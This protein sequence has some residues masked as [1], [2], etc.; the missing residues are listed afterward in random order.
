MKSLSR[1]NCGRDKGGSNKTGQ[2]HFITKPLSMEI[3]GKQIC[4]LPYMID[5]NLADYPGIEQLQDDFY[6]EQV[7]TNNKNQILSAKL[8]LLL[9]YFVSPLMK[10]GMGGFVTQKSLTVIHHYYFDGVAFPG[11]KSKFSFRDVA[12]SSSRLDHQ[13]LQFISGHLHQP[14]YHKNYLCTGS[15]RAQSPLEENDIKGIFSYTD[16]RFHFY[17]S[18]VNYYFA[19]ERQKQSTSL[20][21]SAFSPL[22][23]AEIQAHHQMLHQQT[24]NNLS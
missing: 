18:G 13:D 12:L 4:F 23:L 22:S 10:G 11:Q 7:K 6:H 9:Q 20:L 15:V 16:N 24:Q 14:F 8:H 17:E 19:L 3:E 5:I 21:E 2:L 1:Q